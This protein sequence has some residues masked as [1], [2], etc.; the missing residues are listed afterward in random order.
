MVLSAFIGADLNSDGFLDEEEFWS[1]LQSPTLALTLD[2]EL[3]NGLATV[4]SVL[5]L[6]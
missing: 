5:T 4:E 2:Q 6:D 1:V 3:V